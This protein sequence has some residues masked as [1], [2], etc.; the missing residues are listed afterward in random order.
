MYCKQNFKLQTDEEKK[1]PKVLLI[2]I[3]ILVFQIFFSYTHT[4]FYHQNI[5][6]YHW[7]HKQH[8]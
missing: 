4:Y 3:N 2:I 8:V 5:S 6:L 1:A 7:K